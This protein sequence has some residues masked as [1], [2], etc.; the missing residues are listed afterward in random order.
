MCQDNYPEILGK[1]YII[2]APFIFSGIWL[3]VKPWLDEKTK[4]KIKI[5][6]SGYQKELLSQIDAENLP[7]FLGG[8]STANLVDN[9]GPWNPTGEKV[10]FGKD[11]NMFLDRNIQ[12]NPEFV[13]NYKSTG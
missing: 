6:G 3:I 10:M 13:A 12:N 5:L 1:M 7:D 4:A 8:T 2:N 9:V 11:K